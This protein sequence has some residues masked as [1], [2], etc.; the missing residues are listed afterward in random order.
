M[1][2]ISDIGQAAARLYPFGR[3]YPGYKSRSCPNYWPT[4]QY[5]GNLV[6]VVLTHPP[7]SMIHGATLST[8]KLMTQFMMARI[9]GNLSKAYNQMPIIRTEAKANMIITICQRFLLN[10]THELRG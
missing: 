5:D 2:F 6:S 7:R 10:Y 3:F 8:I 9:S 1:V 4:K